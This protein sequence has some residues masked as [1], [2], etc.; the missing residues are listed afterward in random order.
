MPMARR[1]KVEP[2]K[3][4]PGDTGPRAPAAPP[5]A[6]TR[7]VEQLRYDLARKLMLFASDWRRCPRPACRRAKRCAEQGL[8][9][10]TPLPPGRPM[11]EE[12]EAEMLAQLK[13]ALERR[14]AEIG[15]AKG[16]AR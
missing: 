11:T 7:D 13:R 4:K 14:Q 6:P 16:T 8:D 2:S 9:C 10:D 5:A 1:R 15:S 12:Q 3:T